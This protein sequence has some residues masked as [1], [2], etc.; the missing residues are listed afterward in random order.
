MTFV[1]PYHG[2]ISAKEGIDQAI[3]LLELA[4]REVDHSD[5]LTAA[6]KLNAANDYLAEAVYD[7]C[8]KAF[9]SGITKKRLAATLGVPASTFRGLQK[10]KP[11]PSSDGPESL[12][13]LLN[14]NQ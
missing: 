7:V 10:S 13:S 1:E 6:R 12:K 5:W 14:L 8:Q 3:A 11:K 9:D 2:G 4:H